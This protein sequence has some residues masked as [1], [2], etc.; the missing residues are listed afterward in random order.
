MET[1][2]LKKKSKSKSKDK[3]EESVWVKLMPVFVTIL[4]LIINVV[5]FNRQQANNDRLEFKRRLWEKRLTAYSELGDVVAKLVTTKD[6]VEFLKQADTFDQH[7]WGKLPLFED[8]SLEISM[9]SFRFQIEDKK[10][11]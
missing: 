2:G 6:R 9:K 11:G 10:D 3:K 5:L 1:E 4:G 7:Y 8:D